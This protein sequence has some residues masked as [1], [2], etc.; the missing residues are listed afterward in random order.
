MQLWKR[1]N[2][3]KACPQLLKALTP[4]KQALRAYGIA[5][6]STQTTVYSIRSAKRGEPLLSSF[7]RVNESRRVTNQ[8][9]SLQQESLRSKFKRGFE[10]G[11]NSGR[12]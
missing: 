7:R 8:F 3:L 5:S 12:V 2:G 4:T 10:T 9:R 11:R 6:L 1:S